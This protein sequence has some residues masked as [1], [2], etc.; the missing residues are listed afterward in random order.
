MKSIKVLL[1]VS[2]M[3]LLMSCQNKQRWYYGMWTSSDNWIIKITQDSIWLVPMLP[4]GESGYAPIYEGTYTVIDDGPSLPYLRLS[5]GWAGLSRET[6]HDITLNKEDNQIT[7]G[8]F[9]KYFSKTNMSVEDFERRRIDYFNN[10]E[11]YNPYWHIGRWVSPTGSVLKITDEEVSLYYGWD[12]NGNPYN[13]GNV[14]SYVNYSYL[15]LYYTNTESMMDAGRLLLNSEDKT[16]TD[17]SDLNQGKPAEQKHEVFTKCTDSHLYK[18]FDSRL[19]LLEEGAKAFKEEDAKRALKAEE[20]RKKIDEEWSKKVKKEAEK[21]PSSFTLLNMTFNKISNSQAE[22]Q[23]YGSYYCYYPSEDGVWFNPDD[24]E[25]QIS[26]SSN[27]LVLLGKLVEEIYS[28]GSGNVN[29]IVA[30][31][32]KHYNGVWYQS[33]IDEDNIY[34]AY[35]GYELE[36]DGQQFVNRQ[37]MGNKREQLPYNSN[38]VVLMKYEN[39]LWF[40]VSNSSGAY[41]LTKDGRKPK[42]LTR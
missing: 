16:I 23:L 28:T 7:Y 5:D 4:E 18:E 12:T 3:L 2:L 24:G 30:T 40:Y 15:A 10:E 34:Y 25:H 6:P 11:R 27:G 22:R 42:Q 37:Y 33:I 13:K 9:H 21:Y 39:R 35:K 1:I 20:V 32:A 14:Y 29:G 36:V 19:A 31:S 17:Y 8:L 41:Q 26:I 38:R